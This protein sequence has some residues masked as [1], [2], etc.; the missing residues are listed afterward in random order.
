MVGRIFISGSIDQSVLIYICTVL[1]IYVYSLTCFTFHVCYSAL[2]IMV[3]CIFL[4]FR[5][6]L[7]YWKRLFTIDFILTV[8]LII[9]SML[10]SRVF[11]HNVQLLMLLQNSLLVLHYQLKIKTQLW[12]FLSI[13]FDTIDYNILLD[14]L[15]Y[16]GIRGLALEW[17][18]N[19]LSDRT[20]FV[21]YKGNNSGFQNVTCDVPQGSVLCPLYHWLYIYLFYINI[22]Y[23]K[24]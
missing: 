14:K 16:Y 20:Q 2:Y 9:Y 5:R 21:S 18:R 12:L 15:N 11:N 19:Y 17:F 23:S 6:C 7:K 1:I 8:K 3:H 13:S 22:L 10:I 4:Y 24:L